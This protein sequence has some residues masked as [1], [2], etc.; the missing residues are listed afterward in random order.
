MGSTAKWS[1]AFY[2]VALL[3]RW[4]ARHHDRPWCRSATKMETRDVGDPLGCRLGSRA[5]YH[6]LS[7]CSMISWNDSGARWDIRAENLQVPEHT[8]LMWILSCTASVGYLSRMTQWK[9]CYNQG[10]TQRRSSLPSW[11]I[12]YRASSP[13]LM[14]C[15]R[16]TLRVQKQDSNWGFSPIL[17]CRLRISCYTGTASILG[18]VILRLFFQRYSCSGRRGPSTAFGVCKT[19]RWSVQ[20][21]P[22]GNPCETTNRVMCVK[23]LIVPV[24]GSLFLSFASI[25]EACHVAQGA[26][27]QNV[28]IPP[29]RS[30]TDPAKR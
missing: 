17:C 4:L 27:S 13:Y 10:Q 29:G 21:C 12:F 16:R 19:M 8:E 2:S 20:Y 15:R 26:T 18:Q 9:V 23:R 28:K 3:Y 24:S 14:K 11:L 25:C 6:L 22:W 7:I 1:L 30:L 5:I